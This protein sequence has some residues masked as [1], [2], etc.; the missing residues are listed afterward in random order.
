M[1]ETCTDNRFEIIEKAKKHI[2]EATNISTSPDEMKVLDNFLYRCWQM[3]WL[4]KY[5]LRDD[6]IHVDIYAV[7]DGKRYDMKTSDIKDIT[8]IM[9]DNLMNGIEQICSLG[10]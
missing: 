4:K 3:G 7:K 6:G 5:E 9:T 2:L 1:N 8:K 10:K